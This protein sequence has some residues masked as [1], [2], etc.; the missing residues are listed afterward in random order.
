MP[1]FGAC[2][3]AVAFTVGAIVKLVGPDGAH[4]LGHA[5]GDMNVVAGVLVGLGGHQPQIGAD[6]A[7]ELDLFDGLGLGH[8]DD[9]TIAERIADQGEAD[10]GIPRGA[11]DDDAAGLEAAGALGVLDDGQAG[12]VLHGAAGVHELR[13]AEN[14]A[15]GFLRRA[16]QPD[17]RRVADGGGKA[18]GDRRSDGGEVHGV[19]SRGGRGTCHGAGDDVRCAV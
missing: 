19:S 2:G 9:T 15:A 11:F 7:Q 5:A 14:G 1:D 6:H 17:Q 4:L 10:A 13:L 16:A 12:A 3:G 18:R 8:H